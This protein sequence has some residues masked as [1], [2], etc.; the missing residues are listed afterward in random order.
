MVAPAPTQRTSDRPAAI[1][2]RVARAVYGR[3]TRRKSLV[4]AAFAVALIFMLAL[5]VALGPATLSLWE[6][7][8]TI[9]AP[10]SSSAANQVIVW[11]IRLPMALMAVVIGASLSVAGA[12]MQTILNNP[13]ASPFTLGISAAAGFGAALAIVVGVGVIPVAGNFL[14]ATNAFV[15]ALLASL[16]IYLVSRL[17][18]V[19]TETMVLLG[20]ALVFLFSSLLA[21]L[22]Y[23]ASEQALQQVVFWSLGSLAK[24]TWAKIA[25]ATGVLLLTIPLFM[26]R[27][28]QLTAL[29][30]GDETANS[31]GI[32]VEALRLNVLLAVSL[33]AA[34][35]VAFVGTIGFVGL[36]GPH[37]ARM[38]VGEDQRYFLPVAALS[39][40]IL[41]SATSIVSKAII[42]GVIMPIGIISSLIG[43]PFFLSL[44]LVKRRQLW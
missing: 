22:Q 28:W 27:V 6:V 35:S 8:S 7:L 16:F 44:I 12:E 9:V 17:K 13:L 26:K 38:L 29:R 23:I 19:T 40:A 41:L 4:L 43:V 36:V 10:G 24:A 2:A 37:V 20:I 42:P 32:N 18:G 3:I 5:D 39:G 14:V 31:L 33:L 1:D 25:I 15:F 21:F 30:L 34:T 11:D